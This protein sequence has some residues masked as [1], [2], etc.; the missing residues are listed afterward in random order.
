MKLYTMDAVIRETGDTTVTLVVDADK[1]F[2]LTSVHLDAVNVYEDVQ[3]DERLTYVRER[4]DELPP[5]V[6]V[7]GTVVDGAH[8]VAAA[9]AQGRQTLRAFAMIEKI[10]Q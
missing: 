4:L 9:R 6:V 8:R 10:V 2:Y 1:L 7:D 3:E 5:I